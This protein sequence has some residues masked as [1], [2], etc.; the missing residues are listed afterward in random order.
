MLAIKR[1]LV[2]NARTILARYDCLT[3]Y[4]TSQWC[5]GLRTAEILEDWYW[6]RGL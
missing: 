5:L 1:D 4:L 2:K 6:T 3:D